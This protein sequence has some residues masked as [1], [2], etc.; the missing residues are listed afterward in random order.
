MK[1]DYT[2]FSVGMRDDENFYYC[3]SDNQK[4]RA[5]LFLWLFGYF[6]AM[7]GLILLKIRNLQ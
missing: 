5:V 2:T 4:E 7:N 1:D 3:D 6:K